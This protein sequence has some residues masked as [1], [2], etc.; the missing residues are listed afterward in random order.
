M[1]DLMETLKTQ[2]KDLVYMSEADFAVKPFFWTK[3]EIGTE[4]LTPDK[5]KTLV[6]LKADAPIETVTFEN[7]FAPAT[8]LEDWF[9][10]EEKQSAAQFQTLVATLKT[11]LTELTVHKIGEAKKTVVVIGKTCDNDYA[12]VTTKVVET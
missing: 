9:G 6:K 5:I 10:D 3:A 2:T 12:G 7:F 4:P 8:T 11:Q 1:S